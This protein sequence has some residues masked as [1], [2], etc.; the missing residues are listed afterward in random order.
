MPSEK[1]AKVSQ[2]RFIRNRS[3]RRALRTSRT[4]VERAI[5][6]SSPDSITLANQTIQEI[7]K[8]TSKNVIHR[9]KA[10]RLKSRLAKKI[11]ALSSFTN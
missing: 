10:A 7:D 2:K 6:Q 9:N 5:V 4:K 1:S 8:A 3:V 11:I